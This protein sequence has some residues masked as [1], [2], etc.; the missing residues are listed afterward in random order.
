MNNITLSKSQKNEIKK[1]LKCERGRR[2]F[3]YFCHLL[4]PII[5]T[6]YNTHLK[7]W[8]RLLQDFYED[9]KTGNI[10]LLNGPPRHGKTLSLKLFV[11]W[12]YLH[13]KDYK[14]MVIE[15]DADD[16]IDFGKEV[17]DFIKRERKFEDEIVFSDIAPDVKLSNGNSAK[18]KWQLEGTT[19]ISFIS[20]SPQ[21]GGINGKGANFVIL[22]DMLKGDSEVY[23]PTILDK[24]YKFICDTLF[25]R[26]ENP[27]KMI[28]ISTRWSSD[29]P[30]GRM[31]KNKTFLSKIELH[32]YK[33]MLDDGKMLAPKMFSKEDYE[34]QKGVSNNPAIFFANYQQELIDTKDKLYNL[35]TYNID[36]LPK[37][38]KSG[39][40][41]IYKKMA[42]C[43]TAD[44]GTDYTCSIAFMMY[45]KN[46]Y[47]TD[48]YYTQKPMSE[49][50]SELA[51]F[52]YKNDLSLLI[53]EANNGGN[54]YLSNVEKLYQ[55]ISNSTKCVFK[56]F[57]QVKNKETRVLAQAS[58]INEHIYI[59]DDFSVTH[60]EWFV[61]ISKF[62]SVFK[63]NAH[64]DCADALTIIADN[65]N[66]INNNKHIIVRDYYY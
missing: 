26:R 29:D 17:R 35:K 6:N 2:D 25:S 43:D 30:T 49:T 13:N 54:I 8:C 53:G 24:K 60:S 33:A 5:F 57:S 62:Q 31:L 42:V 21:S 20:G 37:F 16:A 46:I 64:D 61:D 56:P 48:V 23:N 65:C 32:E 34:I 39:K 52:I 63:A 22:D 58:W 44:K 19:Q 7:E 41:L 51:N 10:F 4:V 55:N 47:I 12:L 66:N 40:Q 14:V 18:D 11:C 27:K 3:W 15:Y 1:A 28:S 50:E 36:Q 9:K 38:D 45:N 59:P